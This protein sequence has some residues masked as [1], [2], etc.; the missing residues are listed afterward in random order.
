[1]NVGFQAGVAQRF[2]GLNGGCGNG[3]N[4]RAKYF[5][6]ERSGKK[7]KRYYRPCEIAQDRL[8]APLFILNSGH[9]AAQREVKKIKLD[10]GRGV[11]K[12]LDIALHDAAGPLQPRA[13][14]PGTDNADD[15]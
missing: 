6:S 9:Q 4:A 7:R 11:A 13:L 14:Q 5:D 2:G 12:K 8:I 15:D 1:M 10:Q 3:F